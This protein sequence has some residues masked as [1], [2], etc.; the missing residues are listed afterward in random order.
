MTKHTSELTS[1]IARLKRRGEYEHYSSPAAA[2]EAAQIGQLL[3]EAVE[4]TDEQ[5]DA[6][7][8]S[9]P[10]EQPLDEDQ[11]RAEVEDVLSRAAAPS[12]SSVREDED[13]IDSMP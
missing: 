1:E 2:V 5:V 7:W 3:A 12:H 4:L 9:I 11:T 13:D 8:D 6:L 10:E